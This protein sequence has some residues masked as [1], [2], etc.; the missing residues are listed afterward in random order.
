MRILVVEDEIRQQ[1]WLTRN[2]SSAVHEVTAAEAES[3][4]RSHAVSKSRDKCVT[5]IFYDY[6]GHAWH[7][8]D[9]CHCMC[10]LYGCVETKTARHRLPPRDKP[11]GFPS[12]AL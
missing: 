4:G 11:P 10:G 5:V 8:G 2:L 9:D 6:P 3:D 1:E 12:S 7:R